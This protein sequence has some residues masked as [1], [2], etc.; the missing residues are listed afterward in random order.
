M[1]FPQERYDQVFVPDIGR[2]DGE[3]GL[4]HLDRRVLCRTPP[5]LRQRALVAAVLLHEM[6]HM[7]FGD[8]VT[9][10]WWDDLWLNE[11]FASFA[12]TWASV[13]APSTPTPGPPSSPGEQ[14]AAYQQDMGPASHPIRTAVPDVAHA[15]ANFDAITYYKG[16]AVL[17]QLMAYVDRGD[18]RRGAARLLRAST[19]GATPAGGPDARLGDAAGRDLTAWTSALAGPGRHR[20]DQPGRRPRC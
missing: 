10:R 2:R 15:F 5:T 13:S 18:V 12:S 1:P 11:A 6:A 8:M 17:H 20:H 19:P 9:M 4:R 16:E 14:I 3:L 7:W